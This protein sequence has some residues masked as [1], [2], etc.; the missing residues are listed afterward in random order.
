MCDKK[1]KTGRNNNLLKDG[2]I[3][4]IKMEKALSKA[5]YTET[6]FVHRFLSM[7]TYE[8]FLLSTQSTLTKQILL[9]HHD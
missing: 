1:N 7:V 9:F 4:K 5:L 6:P 3:Y 2:A 8:F